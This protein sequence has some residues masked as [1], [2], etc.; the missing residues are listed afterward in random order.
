ME[1]QEARMWMNVSVNIL[2]CTRDEGK[3][4]QAELNDYVN[5]NC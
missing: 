5:Y 2:R 4:I 3:K 1:E